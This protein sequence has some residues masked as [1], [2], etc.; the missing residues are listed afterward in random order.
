M[1][2]GSNDTSFQIFQRD[3][4]ALAFRAFWDA[5]GGGNQIRMYSRT[6]TP[7]VHGDA[8]L[9]ATLTPTYEYTYNIVDNSGRIAIKY[10]VTQ[11]VS[12]RLD[13]E[14]G[15]KAHPGRHLQSVLGG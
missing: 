9:H 4:F 14:H 13:G 12:R 10:T 2:K 11:E 7:E 3:K 15:H 5:R 1:V 8:N 6:A